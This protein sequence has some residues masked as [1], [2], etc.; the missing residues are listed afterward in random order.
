MI[1]STALRELVL[2]S[3][4][5]AMGAAVASVVACGCGCDPVPKPR[6]DGTWEVTASLD[7]LTVE[8]VPEVDTVIYDQIDRMVTVTY[9][10]PRDGERY[11]ATFFVLGEWFQE[12]F[13]G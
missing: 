11:V 13:E 9:I 12:G 10:S 4:C 2:L 5:V 1:G 7:D 6:T 8:D 3:G